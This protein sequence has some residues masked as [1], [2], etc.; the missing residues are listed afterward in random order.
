MYKECLRKPLPLVVDGVEWACCTIDDEGFR[1]VYFDVNFE[2]EPFWVFEKLRPWLD[3]AMAWMEDGPHF[4][5]RDR[6]SAKRA[7]RKQ[8]DQQQGASNGLAEG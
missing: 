8:A 1:S 5:E 2:V 4:S 7:T 6:Q 3:K